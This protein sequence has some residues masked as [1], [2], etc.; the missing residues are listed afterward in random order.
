MNNKDTQSYRSAHGEGEY[1]ITV[2]SVS[3]H[4]S[5]VVASTKLSDT[6]WR[7][8]T[9]TDKSTK[10]QNIHLSGI[11]EKKQNRKSSN[12]IPGHTQPDYATGTI[13]VQY[14]YGTHH[15]NIT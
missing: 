7:T 8:Y 6:T 10:V 12:A 1:P 9:H 11:S 2:L 13:R 3:T 5:N 15:T 14:G 4:G